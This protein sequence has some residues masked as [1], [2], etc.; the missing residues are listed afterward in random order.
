MFQGS[1]DGLK[2][3]YGWTSSRSF[4]GTK[5]IGLFQTASLPSK[6]NM[7]DHLICK[8]LSFCSVILEEGGT[9]ACLSVYYMPRALPSG[10][11]GLILNIMSGC[12]S[13]HFTDEETEMQIDSIQHQR[14]AKR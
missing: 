2:A 13:L 4:M 8:N 1:E 11:F 10:T 6:F 3:A 5:P 7:D 12:G 14:E 9:L